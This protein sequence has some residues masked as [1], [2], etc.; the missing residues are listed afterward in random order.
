M[1][2]ELL[3]DLNKLKGRAFHV[4][5]WS[6]DVIERYHAT[7]ANRK[8]AD[9][10]LLKGLYEWIFVPPTL[11]PFNVHLVL[12]ECL[13]DFEKDRPLDAELSLLIKLLP[14]APDEAVCAGVAEHELN[15]A[16]G[17]YEDLVQTQAKYSQ[18]E[19]AIL[20]D[21]E[22]QSQWAQIKEVFTITDYQ[23]HK[24]VIRRSMRA[25]RNFSLSSSF[26]PRLPDDAFQAAFDAFCLRWNLYGMQYDE[27][28]LLKLSV[29]VTPYGT[30]VHI[31]AY[32]SFDTKRDIRW[33]AVAKLHRLRVQGRQG[34]ALAEGVAER[35]ELAKKLQH[36]DEEAKRRCLKGN[37]KHDYLCAGLGWVPETSPKRISRLRAEFK[38]K[39]LVAKGK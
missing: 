3:H 36:L 25:E 35:M 30:M 21:P 29:N 6:Q 31:P 11:W 16:K 28:L 14:Q 34:P 37:E 27:P 18:N 2:K 23:E 1:K 5:D 4:A 32:W 33:D 26:N 24:G 10:L 12:K 8:N 17:V 20:A 15:V 19:R 38:D 22:L 9:A 7:A 13:K 39:Q